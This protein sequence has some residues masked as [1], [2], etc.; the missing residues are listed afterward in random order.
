[1]TAKA[2]DPLTAR[3]LEIALLAVKGQRDTEIARLLGIALRTVHA[4]MQNI[5][6]KAGVSNRVQLLNWL[7]DQGPG[8]PSLP[9]EP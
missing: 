3:Q 8:S 1:M 4:H 7:A 6:T 5:Y 9:E 2:G